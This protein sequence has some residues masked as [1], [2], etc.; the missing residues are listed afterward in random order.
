MTMIA[1]FLASFGT[2]VVFPPPPYAHVAGRYNL[3]PFV[4]HVLDK[5]PL[6]RNQLGEAAQAVSQVETA[7]ISFHKGQPLYR[8]RE[9]KHVAIMAIGDQA[10]ARAIGTLL[11]NIAY[12]NPRSRD[13]ETLEGLG[14]HFPCADALVRIG[15]PAMDPVLDKLKLTDKNGR[16]R[17]N[18]CWVL[19]EYYGRNIARRLLM[20][21]LANTSDDRLRRN[22]S[23]ALE[24]YF[25]TRE[26]G[27]PPYG[28][29][30]K[31]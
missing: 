10:D 31:D 4:G 30:Y 17:H 29:D 18:L 11:A 16:I 25:S 6:W 2:V 19:N 5:L 26:R 13:T 21:E 8:W 20:E 28:I 14:F 9:P 27:I 24:P 3:G 22:L 12:H 7:P 1:V 23:G 15:R